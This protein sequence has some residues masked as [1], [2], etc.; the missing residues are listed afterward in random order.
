MEK[1]NKPTKRLWIAATG[2]SLNY[3]YRATGGTCDS[4]KL[5]KAIS[6]YLGIEPYTE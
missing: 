2:Y 6:D 5:V 4:P 1:A 3:I